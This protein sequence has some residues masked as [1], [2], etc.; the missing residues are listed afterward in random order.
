[1]SYNSNS[2]EIVTL[3]VKFQESELIIL[4]CYRPHGGTEEE[5]VTDRSRVFNDPNLVNKK[6][7]LL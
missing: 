6:V 3:F 1:M 4:G 2:I 5:F 7:M